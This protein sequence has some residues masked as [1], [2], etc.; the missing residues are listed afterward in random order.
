MRKMIPT[1][2]LA[3]GL[4]VLTPTAAFA[5]GTSSTESPDAQTA[6]WSSDDTGKYYIMTD[7][8]RA[9]GICS[10]E[11]KLYFFKPDGY[12]YIPSAPG[13]TAI[14]GKL[15]YILGDGSVKT[16]LFQVDTAQG[17]ACYCANSQGQLYTK[18]ALSVGGKI[19]C[20]DATGRTYGKGLHTINKRKYLVTASGTAKTGRQKYQG[21]VYFFG[22]DGAMIT[23]KVKYNDT[24]YFTGKN[25]A[26]RKKGW[27]TSKGKTYY[28]NSNGTLYT[29]WKKSRGKWYYLDKKTGVRKQ[30]KWVVKNNKRCRLGKNGALLTKWYKVGG[31]KYYGTTSGVDIGARFTGVHQ[32]GKKIYVFSSSGSLGKGWTIYNGKKYYTNLK[33]EIVRGFKKIGK[34]TYFFN[35]YGIMHTGWL[36]HNGNFYYMNPSDGSMVTGTKTIS[37]QTYTFSKSGISSRSLEGGWTVKVNRQQNVVTVY[38]G[39]TPVRAMLCSTGLNNATPLGTFSIKDKLYTHMLNGPTYGYYCSHIT[40]DILFHSIPQHEMGRRNLP[41]YKY[42][43]LGSQ[44]SQGCIRL[45]MSDAYW[46]YNNVPVGTTVVIYDSSDPGP[47]GKPRGIHIPSSQNYDPTDP[48]YF[49]TG[50]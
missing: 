42:N 47:L 32:L 2:F 33:G 31:K 38:K 50:V 20:F 35:D 40:N 44:A 22:S 46:L 10:I 41:A 8:K 26:L 1:I 37:G 5:T 6:G 14:D 27:V 45:G 28:V 3:A 7:G 43:M 24:L 17:K 19:Y 48:L 18:T 25:G 11:D 23:G 9:S 4:A 12:L 30:D 36:C 21:N 29:G 39:G 16:G 13:A 15:Y 49:N 34:K